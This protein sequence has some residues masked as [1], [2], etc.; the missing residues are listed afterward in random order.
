MMRQEDVSL[1]R[2][3]EHDTSKVLRN[4]AFTATTVLALDPG[5]H[6]YM[7][8]Y[9]MLRK[10]DKQAENIFGERINPAP[11]CFPHINFVPGPGVVIGY[12]ASILCIL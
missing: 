5:L 12:K 8:S 9:E 10:E 3:E 7:S 11:M 6:S 1:Q 4:A 2:R